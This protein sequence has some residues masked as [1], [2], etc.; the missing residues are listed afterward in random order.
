MRAKAVVFCDAAPVGIHHFWPLCPR[1]N[2][3][4]PVVFIGKATPGP[5]QVGYSDFL[6]CFNNV[7]ANAVFLCHFHGVGY[8]KAIVDTAAQVLGKMPVNV[9]ADGV[10]LSGVRSNGKVNLVCEYTAVSG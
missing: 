3:V 10:A 8:P 9:P 2:A 5:A 6:Q 4:T 7:Q 1:A